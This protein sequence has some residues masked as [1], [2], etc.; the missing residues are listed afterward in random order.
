MKDQEVKGLDG[1]A[2]RDKIQKG[3][4]KPHLSFTNVAGYSCRQGQRVVNYESIGKAMSKES[5][6]R[7]GMGDV[8]GCGQDP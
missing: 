3:V 1:F 4:D 6:R 8:K 5:A 2:G 7:C